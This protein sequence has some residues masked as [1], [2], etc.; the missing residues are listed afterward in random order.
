M[1]SSAICTHAGC[2]QPSCGYYP[3][4]RSRVKSVRRGSP[5][6]GYIETR[7]CTALLE[8]RAGDHER[9]RGMH[10]PT[11]IVRAASE[12]GERSERA[13][14]HVAASAPSATTSVAKTMKHTKALAENMQDGEQCRESEWNAGWPTRSW[15]SRVF[16][17]R[18]G[19]VEGSAPR[20]KRGC[21]Q[22]HDG[23]QDASA[24]R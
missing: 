6:R 17:P 8:G 4:A 18:R 3:L 20:P 21:I 2:G 7:P 23:L 19:P 15:P 16:P 5:P 22:V 13:N 11:E 9:H 14:H 12:R 1:Q 24:R 10:C